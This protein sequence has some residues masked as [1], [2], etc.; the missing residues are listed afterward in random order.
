[1]WIL[2]SAYAWSGIA[3]ACRCRVP[4]HFVLLLASESILQNTLLYGLTLDTRIINQT[5]LNVA[6]LLDYQCL[7]FAI[8]SAEKPQMPLVSGTTKAQILE[9][10]QQ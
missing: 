5:L 8:F 9:W 10:T 3:I 6:Q 7:Y 1:M 4:T 2:H